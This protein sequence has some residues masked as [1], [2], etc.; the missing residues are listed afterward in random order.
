VLTTRTDLS[1]GRTLSLSTPLNAGSRRLLCAIAV[2]FSSVAS[3]AEPVEAPLTEDDAV[4]RALRRA[5]LAEIVRGAVE[6]ES[7]AATTAR[8]YP[9]PQLAYRREQ[10]YGALGTGEDYLSLA[11]SFDLGN[12]RGLRG[13]AGDRRA[14]AAEREG[15][16]TRVQVAADARLRFFETLHRQ[17]RQGALDAWLARVDDALGIVARRQARGDAALYDRRRLER[18][19]SVVRAR[20]D[21]ERASFE[22]ARARLVVFV[23]LPVDAAARL[24]VRGALL[25]SSEPAS[26]ASLR[27]TI[28][29]RPDLVAQAERASA[30]ELDRLAARRWWLPDLQLEGGWKGVDARAGRTDGFLFGAVLTLPLWD[31]S[32]GLARSAEGA[33]RVALGRRALLETE[34]AGEVAGLREEATR[35]LDAA[36]RFRAESRSASADLVR[37]A[38]AGYQGGEMTVLELL[39]AY[40]GAADDELT[41]LDLELAARRARVDLDRATATGPR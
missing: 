27:S 11:Q 40:R 10:N 15:D 24:V 17:E 4:E 32:V 21:A 6:I 25:P 37:I 3:A 35:L 41:A 14:R 38:T 30:A 31:R 16:A 19:K 12:R 7:G 23:D 8:T 29:K 39:D 36:R 33:R 20:L 34:L 5:P 28:A 18:E 9:T 26:L 2:L 13:E 1:S 22:R